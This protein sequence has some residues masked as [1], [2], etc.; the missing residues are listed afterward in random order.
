MTV[1]IRRLGVEDGGALTLFFRAIETDDEATAFFHPHAFDAQTA[2]TISESQNTARD[3]YFAA[4]DG[5]RILGYAML[6]GWDE[7]YE[8]PSFG[9][10]VSPEARG[11]GLGGQLLD[12]A[13]EYA[14]AQG[15][16]SV[17]LKVYG[18]NEVARHLYEARGFQFRERTPD[19]HQLVGRLDLM[20]SKPGPEG[21]V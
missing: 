1:S 16:L 2:R 21:D 15:A 9:I 13:I 20:R 12:H 3:A 5:G 10:Y 18:T 14:H 11:R 6:R 7:G 8:V 19:C 4:F 17:M